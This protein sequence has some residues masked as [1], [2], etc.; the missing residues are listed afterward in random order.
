[1]L[2][3]L[4]KELEK[5]GHKFVRYTDDC[6]ILCKS[7]RAAQR[8][9]RSIVVFIENELFSKVNVEKTVVAHIKD[10]KFLGYSFYIYKD[11]CFFGYT[12][13]ALPR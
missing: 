4:D 9:L 13:R 12:P 7:K 6:M 1:M 5:R 11:K 10:V 3:E 8:T 2:N